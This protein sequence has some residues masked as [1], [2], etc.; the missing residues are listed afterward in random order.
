ME[1]VDA[2]ISTGMVMGV[3]ALSYASAWVIQRIFSK[4]EL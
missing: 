4:G 2:I 1:Y 3:F